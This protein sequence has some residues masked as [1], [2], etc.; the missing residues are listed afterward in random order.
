MSEF[1]RIFAI[2]L[3][4]VE[5]GSAGSCGNLDPNMSNDSPPGA[6]RP[7]AGGEFTWPPT[8]EE[9]DAIEVIPLD[10]SAPATTPA[11]RHAAPEQVTA[12]EGARRPTRPR[13]PRRRNR[14]LP[15][16][17]ARPPLPVSPATLVTPTPPVVA[18]VK[19]LHRRLHVPRRED[20]A[21]LGVTL[22]SAL[23]IAVAATLS[24][25]IGVRVAGGND[26][27][28]SHER[29]GDGNGPASSS[30]VAGRERRAD[31]TY[32]EGP[33]RRCA[34]RARRDNAPCD[35][36]ASDGGTASDSAGSGATSGG[37]ERRFVDRVR[38]RENRSH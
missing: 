25:R 3:T 34:R 23:A 14:R 33:R 29:T 32:R 35:S 30:R 18:T 22:T 2:F 1:P 38:V 15:R 10:G 20:V 12:L 5:N 36:A 9:L 37:R 26:R 4:T 17:P 16:A 21:Y 24:S 11:P 28:S 8:S 7:R 31:A 27:A 6:S 13:S 19:T